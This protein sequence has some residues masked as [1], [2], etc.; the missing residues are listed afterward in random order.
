MG[1][2]E[3]RPLEP[4]KLL[5]W[6]GRNAREGCG[7]VGS[8][9]Q[10][11]FPFS[12]LCTGPGLCDALKSGA[13]TQ[14]VSPGYTPMCEEKGGGFSPVQCDLSQDSCWCVL[15]NGEEVPGTRVVGTQP[16]CESKS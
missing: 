3:P 6:C 2:I 10:S 4:Y 8:K 15:D 1:E 13:L 16:A 12:C 11:V 5:T 7:K 14:K 9:H